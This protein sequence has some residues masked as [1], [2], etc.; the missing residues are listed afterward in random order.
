MRLFQ[1]VF[2]LLPVFA[3]LSVS[4][5]GTNKNTALKKDIK[6]IT[7]LFKK[8]Q[9][10]SSA[11]AQA[12]AGNGTG[13]GSNSA[14]KG[15]KLDHAGEPAPGA[16]VIDADQLHSFNA[17]AAQIRK[18]SSS[19]LIDSAGNFIVPYNTYDFSG[20][21]VAGPVGYV[22]QY[23]GIYAYNNT[24]H[25]W[26][27]F[28]NAQG[29][30][31][32]KTGLATHVIE[33]TDNKQMLKTNNSSYDAISYT[34]TTAGGNNYSIGY[35]LENIIDGIG[36]VRTLVNSGYIYSY[37]KLTG[38]TIAGNFD[39]ASP[40]S[41]G[42][43]RV[44]KK[45]A[46]GQLQFG[47]INKNGI[48]VIPFSFSVVPGNFSGGFAKV[49]PK[50]KSAFEYAFINKKGEVVFK[51]TLA[52]ISKNGTFDHFTN[53]GLA[54]SE[55]CVMDTAFNIV[56]NANFFLSYGIPADSWFVGPGTYTQGETNAKLVF[57]TRTARSPYTLQP[58]YGFIN[59]A[60]GKVVM[61]V[62]DFINTNGLYFDPQSHRAYARVCIGKDNKNVLVYR[63]GYINEDGQFVILRGAPSQ[64]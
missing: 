17:G 13:T 46:F 50:D 32:L 36:I 20:L 9:K 24:N 5:Q 37:K 19:A 7:D 53:F 58:V 25:N 52:D 40:F 22:V 44:G 16:K 6:T 62:F 51:Q 60:T 64:W 4:A 27:G 3:V 10:D 23:N 31:L 18:G 59:L 33:L 34:Y 49:Y 57:S 45:D 39:D 2:V 12:A 38:E 30:I 1:F 54:F 11:T 48:L 21:F 43:A 15:S 61:P 42:M 55:R 14:V 63:E 28:M 56:T 8:K 35:M 41:D 47:Y 29:K 26:G